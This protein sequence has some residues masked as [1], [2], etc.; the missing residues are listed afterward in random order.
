M[1][2]VTIYTTQHCPYCVSAKRLLA[3]KGVS[4]VEIDIEASPNHLAE[5]LLRS[6]RR[7]VPQV[8]V[9]SVHVGGFDDLKRLDQKGELEVLLSA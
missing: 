3:H 4:A 2:Q 5:M 9:G 6:R 7:T 1:N 8:F